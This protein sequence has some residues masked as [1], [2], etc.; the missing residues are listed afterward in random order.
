MMMFAGV[1]REGY[2]GLIDIDLGGQSNGRG[3]Y[4]LRNGVFIYEI[5]HPLKSR[6]AKH[7]IQVEPGEIL[8]IRFN[9]GLARKSAVLA[10]YPK[11]YS[12][13]YIPGVSSYMSLKLAKEEKKK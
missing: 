8:G 4:S 2:C 10:E 12:S 6:D 1:T 3:S 11:G 13:S 5:T 7:D 9:L